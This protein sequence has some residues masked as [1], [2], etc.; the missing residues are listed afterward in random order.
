MTNN[1][2]CICIDDEPDDLL[3]LNEYIKTDP[4]LTCAGCFSSASDG[5]QA[6]LSLQPDLVF[7]DIEMPGA[8]GLEIL[9]QLKDRIELA[10]F[11]TS[12]PEFALESFELSAF[13]YILKPVTEK[14]FASTVQR[15]KDYWNMKQKAITYELLH[16]TEILLISEGRH[17]TKLPVNEIIYLEAMQ[18]YTKVVTRQR[19]YLT[20]VGFNAFLNKLP[21]TGFLRI[22]RSYAVASDKINGWVSSDEIICGNATLPVGK[23]YKEIVKNEIT[24]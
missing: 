7:L 18:N 19:S 3:L 24:R 2:R 16:G 17:K 15:L 8:T 5:L 14:R 1:I 23:T 12:H 21:Q 22:H 13:D 9:K 20:L 10:V 4:L 11:V 6:I